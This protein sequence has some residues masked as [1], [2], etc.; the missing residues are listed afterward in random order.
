MN[1]RRRVNR[2]GPQKVNKDWHLK[3]KPYK[4]PWD[5]TLPAWGGLG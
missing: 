4:P 5:M 1:T 3:N 2:R